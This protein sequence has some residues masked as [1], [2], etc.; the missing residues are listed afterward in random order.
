[1]KRPVLFPFV[2]VLLLLT[3]CGGGSTEAKKEEPRPAASAPPLDEGTVGSVSGKVA[4]T[5][6]KPARKTIDM[7][8]V[9]AC[10]E[11]SKGTALTED[12]IV[13]DND[14]LQ[15]AFVYIKEGLPDRPW[16][17]P[18][19]AVR[20]DQLGCL[21]TPHV[22]GLMVN[23]PL[24]ISNSDTT[25]H[26]IHPIPRNNKEWN[27]SQPPKGDLKVKTFTNEEVMIRIGC[28]V[29]PWMR[30]YVG[31]LKHPF[32]SVTGPDGSFVLKGV[33]A[34]EYTLESW[35]ERYG[36]QQIKVKVEPKVEAKAE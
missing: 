35:H 20:L 13:N 33:P 34:G 17:V 1:M 2:S 25:N 3:S 36:T 9:P 26:N 4:F 21:Y 27:E 31:V 15:N 5:G 8:A 28:N 10:K 16:P 24:E 29:H 7:D 18:A 19:T 11:K 22:F 32:F 6:A 23:Q 14:T 12:V 30:A